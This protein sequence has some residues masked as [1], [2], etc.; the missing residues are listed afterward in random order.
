MASAIG[1]GGAKDARRG[2]RRAAWRP[3]SQR[4]QATRRKPRDRARP[5]MLRASVPHRRLTEE[6]V[7]MTEEPFRDDATLALK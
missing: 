1:D 7:T 3:V 2:R 4:R 6:A 5:R